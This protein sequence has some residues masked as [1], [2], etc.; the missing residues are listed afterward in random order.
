MINNRKVVVVMPAYNAA[1]TL[2]KTFD[3]IPFSFIDDIILV[4]DFSSDNTK[5][6]AEELGI[7]HIIR[8]DSNKGYGANQKACYTKALEL[9]A[10]IVIM[11]HADYQ[12]DPRLIPAMCSM[13]AYNIYPVVLGTRILGN[14]ARK[15][16]MPLYKYIANRL[17]T[18]FQNILLNQK[19]SE[20]HTGLRAF[21][22]EVLRA[23]PYQSNNDNFV[24]DNEMLAQIIMQQYTIGEVS[25]PTRYFEE[26]SSISFKKSVI[27]GFGVLRVSLQFR[28]HK[29]GIMRAG[30]FKNV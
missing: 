12:Y 2:S 21:S 28:L 25:C 14:G 1:R 4:D 22:A 16:G 15:G 3:D 9:E 5:A 29:W 18:L 6:V 23:L 24:F 7:K 20:Y 11:I 26:A 17:L 13:I 8:F 19:L 27:Y 10:D 30:L